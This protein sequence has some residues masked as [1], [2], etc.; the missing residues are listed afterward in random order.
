MTLGLEL[1]FRVYSY[2]VG[3]GF[4]VT[5]LLGFRVMV[6]ILESVPLG[7]DLGFTVRV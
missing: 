7:L 5:Y 2:G 4:R 3:L 6:Y 1:G